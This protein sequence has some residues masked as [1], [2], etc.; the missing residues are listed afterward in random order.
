M[1]VL[2]YVQAKRDPVD[3]TSDGVRLTM[4]WGL[5]SKGRFYGSQE[6]QLQFTF[7]TITIYRQIK[8]EKDFN[9]KPGYL[10][11]EKT[12]LIKLQ[13]STYLPTTNSLC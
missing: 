13:I 9:I 3:T 12:A 8:R 2:D 6:K 11:R 7:F 4:F 5:I 10:N 1:H